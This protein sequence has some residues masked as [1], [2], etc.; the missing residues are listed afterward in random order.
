MRTEKKKTTAEG[1]EME[2]S[3]VTLRFLKTFHFAIS[4]SPFM[5][6]AK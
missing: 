3:T 5:S 1:R 6:F 2:A 4:T